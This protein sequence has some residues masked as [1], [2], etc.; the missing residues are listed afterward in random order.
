MSYRV[1]RPHDDAMHPGE[2]ESVVVTLG[3]DVCQLCGHDLLPSW[4]GFDTR[5]CGWCGAITRRGYSS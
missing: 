1:P 3:E 2:P 4:P 5:R